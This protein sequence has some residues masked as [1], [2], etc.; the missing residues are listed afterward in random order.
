MKYFI[1]VGERSGEMHA[2]RLSREIKKN[3]AHAEIV[4]VGGKLMSQE[5]VNVLK[6]YKDFFFMGIW[7]VISNLKKIIRS[8]K[9]IKQLIK[10]YAPDV[11]ILVDCPGVNLKL[12]T[13]AKSQG[14]KTCYYISPKIWAWRSGRIKEIKQSID[15]MLVI[16][17]FET[18]YYSQRN[19]KVEYVGNP[20]ID[21]IGEYQYNN[22]NGLESGKNNIA[23][24]PGSRKQEIKKSI[25]IIKKI[26]QKLQ[27]IIFC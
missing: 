4:G 3:D 10:E 12:A 1:V 19:F 13:F 8:I 14:I 11:L 23:I 7:E 2:A 20:L 22:K 21:A 17:P 24:L 27:N 6:S 15:K 25:K 18:A 16:F 9:H 5:G 26:S